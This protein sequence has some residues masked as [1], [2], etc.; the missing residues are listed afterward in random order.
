MRF[1]NGNAKDG[2]KL[3]LPCEYF[4]LIC[5]T[6]TGRHAWPASN[7]ITTNV[8]ECLEINVV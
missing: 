1:G 7:G 4:D 6:N 8:F 3:S 2:D 5:G